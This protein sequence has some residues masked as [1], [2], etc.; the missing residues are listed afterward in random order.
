MG[1]FGAA[2]KKATKLLS[3]SQLVHRL[4]V[5]LDASR[6]SEW[7]SAGTTVRLSDGRVQG[8]SCLK[9]TAL[10]PLAAA[11]PNPAVLPALL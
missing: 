6:A 10:S 8:T 7:D 5:R 4:H 2:T 11:P 9:D 1:M 3:H